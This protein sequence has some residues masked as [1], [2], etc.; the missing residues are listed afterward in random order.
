METVP[1]CVCS[2]WRGRCKWKID[3]S[4]SEMKDYD[5]ALILSFDLKF[6]EKLDIFFV[7]SRVRFVHMFV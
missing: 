4:M 2:C 3:G 1:T 7:E 6:T 5:N